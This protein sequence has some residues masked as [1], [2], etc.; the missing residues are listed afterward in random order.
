MTQNTTGRLQA[1]NHL[2]SDFEKLSAAYGEEG[3]LFFRNVLDS[4][5]I[6]KVK[7][8]FV[9]VLQKQGV[10]RA[11]ES[12][13]IWTSVGLD[14]IDDNALYALNSYQELLDLESTRRLV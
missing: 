7:Q 3:Y 4:D 10:V 14:Q 9:R 5:A 1:A 13:P 6:L 11:G 12:E 8:E 2:L